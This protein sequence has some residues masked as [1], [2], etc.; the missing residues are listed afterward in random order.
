M[1]KVKIPVSLDLYKAAQQRLHYEGIV[2]PKDLPRLVEAVVNVERD[3]DVKIECGVDEQGL[4][5]IKGKAS[6]EVTTTCQRCNNDM[7]L[8]LA[9]DFAFSPVKEEDEDD[10]LLPE[11]YEPLELERFDEIDLKRLVEDEL[12]LALPLIAMHDDADCNASQQDM[13][14]GEIEEE[15]KPNPFDVLKQIKRN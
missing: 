11:R 5:F 3:V 2:P 14:W 7:K 6:A 4:L 15:E 1:Q 13:S 9:S 10:E 12:I 8:D